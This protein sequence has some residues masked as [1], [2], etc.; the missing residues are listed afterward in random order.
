M[1]TDYSR[2]HAAVLMEQLPAE[3]RTAR[4]QCPS[5]EWSATDYLLWRIEHTLRVIA[6][7]STEDGAKGRRP[8]KPLPTPAERAQLE[9]K[10]QATDIDFVNRILGLPEGV[11]H[12]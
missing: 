3:S 11:E 12:G 10:L 4:A 5:A 6:W 9:R 1:G 8:P 2:R 7:Q